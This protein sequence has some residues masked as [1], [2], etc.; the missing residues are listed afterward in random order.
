MLR[1]FE[2][3]IRTFG[4]LSFEMKRAIETVNST[5]MIPSFKKGKPKLTY[6]LEEMSNEELAL[7]NALNIMDIHHKP[8]KIEGIDAYN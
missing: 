2:G 5:V 1:T 3:E 7:V 6:Q 8:I 4:S